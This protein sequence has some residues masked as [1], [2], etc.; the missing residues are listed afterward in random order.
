LKLWCEKSRESLSRPTP[1]SAAPSGPQCS[2]LPDSGIVSVVTI[3]SEINVKIT[4]LVET[5]KSL[6]ASDCNADKL[7]PIVTEIKA[8]FVA[9]IAQ[10][11]ILVGAKVETVLASGCGQVISVSEFSVLFGALINL[12]FGAISVVIKTAGSAQASVVIS[13][14]VEL[15]VCIGEFIQVVCSAVTFEGGL[16]VILLPI[17]KVSLGVCI[18][19]GI[20]ASFE[21]LQCDFT[22]IGIDLGISVGAAVSLVTVIQNCTTIITPL[23]ENLKGLSASDCTA[24]NI[25]PIVIE[26]KGALTVAIEQI[27]VLIGV[28]VEVVLASGSGAVISVDECAKLVGGLINLVLE[29]CGSVL[30]IVLSVNASAVISI[31]AELGI[32]I[33]ELIKVCVAVVTFDGGLS[34][35]LI[36]IIKN[37]LGLCVTLGITSSFDFLGIDFTQIGIGATVSIVTIV[38]N[39][40]EHV[41]PLIEKL[42]GLS[43]EECTAAKVAL[44]TGSGAVISVEEC[45]KLIGGLVT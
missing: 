42:K 34:V 16:I 31:F 23:I 3:V 36:P 26:I 18:T 14:F 11:K 32:C 15:G 19:L 22:Q 27:K 4:P 38:Q 28:S 7:G 40:T 43:A 20:T 10:V 45:G 13:I 17:I 5:L 8:I 24:D 44:A 39:C 2:A 25:R 12:I 33:S 21:F 35:I 37:S 41:T 9:A 1:S 30:K 29:G 6:S